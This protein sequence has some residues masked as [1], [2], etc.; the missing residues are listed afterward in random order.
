MK[1]IKKTSNTKIEPVIGKYYQD[2]Y[3]VFRVDVLDVLINPYGLI[4]CED[5]KENY[6]SIVFNAELYYLFD[7]DNNIKEITKEAFEIKLKESQTFFNKLCNDLMSN[8]N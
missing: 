8:N 1:I 6:C 3:C 5:K 7:V 4:I 2:D